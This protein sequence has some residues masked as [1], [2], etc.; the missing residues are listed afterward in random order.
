LTGLAEW[1]WQ[2]LLHST[3]VGL[4]FFAWSRSLSLPPGDGRRRLLSV[5]LVLPLLTASVPGRSG[6]AFREGLAWFDGERLLALPLGLDGL[7]CGHLVVV[8][9]VVTAAVTLLQEVLPA[10]HRPRVSS[11]QAPPAVRSAL[12]N[13]EEWEGGSIELVEEEGLEAGLTGS[14]RRPRL[15]LSER[16]VEDLEPAALEMVI[17]HEQ[18]H[19]RAGH[20]LGQHLL[21]LARLFQIHNPIAL[22][23]FRE[24]CV[25]VEID[26][27]RRAARG[28]DPRP[29]V[30]ALLALYEETDPSDHSSR[31]VLRRRVDVLLGRRRLDTG[32]LPGPSFVAGTTL[33][34]LL[35]PWLV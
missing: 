34:A 6:P 22:W 20:W 11:R 3:V 8:L 5:V 24:Y 16:L 1:A 23:V 35:L 9:G 10:F 15:L 17:R 18:A 33:L 30:R 2:V 32:L 4:V 19:R 29:L 27:D 14:R 26:C 7:R 21:F 13:L 31:S 25:E 28:R 12:E